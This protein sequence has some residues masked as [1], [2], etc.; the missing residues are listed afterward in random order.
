MRYAHYFVFRDA[1][2]TSTTKQKL[3]DRH[4]SPL[5]VYIYNISYV[6]ATNRQLLVR[7]EIPF[8]TKRGSSLELAKANATAT[9]HDNMSQWQL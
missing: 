6:D 9:T 7:S 4:E 3:V 2:T 1:T 5:Y 8:Y